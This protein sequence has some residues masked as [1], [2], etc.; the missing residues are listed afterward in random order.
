MLSSVRTDRN[1]DQGGDGPDGDVDRKRRTQRV[2]ARDVLTV[3]RGHRNPIAIAMAFSLIGAAMGLTEPL[4]ATKTIQ[5][6]SAGRAFVPLCACTLLVAV[7]A[8]SARPNR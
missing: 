6:V 2:G 1:S 7:G 3:L 4:I 8:C 5:E